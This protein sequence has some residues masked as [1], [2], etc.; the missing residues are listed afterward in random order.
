M[1]SSG[2]MAKPSKKP[3][4]R[5]HHGDLRRALLDASHALVAEQGAG[6]LALRAVARRLGVSHQAPLHHFADKHELLAALATE[7]FERL[8]AAL[9]RAAER[10]GCDPVARL[11]ATGVAYVRFALEQPELFRLMFGSTLADAQSP[12]LRAAGARAFG[13]LVAQARASLEASGELDADRLDLVTTAAWSLVHGLAL[14]QIDRRLPAVG[15]RDAAALARD[16]TSLV[17]RSLRRS[18]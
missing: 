17:A 10:A 11:E 8:T 9:E 6:G 5:Y 18:G 12:E 7:G 4:G 1:A 3:R 2:S 16:V 13:V 15:P 14:L